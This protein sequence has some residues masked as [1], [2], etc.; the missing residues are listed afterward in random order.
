MGL[1][2][3]LQEKFIFLPTDLDLD[4]QYEFRQ[5]YDEL[6]LNAADG[7]QLNALHFQTEAPQGL[8]VYF[9]G[10]AGDLSRWGDIPRIVLIIKRKLL[11]VIRA[12]IKMNVVYSSL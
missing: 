5:N 11:R 10:N 3:L 6:F 7:A 1:L 8:V 12:V 4:Y 2:Q 9:H